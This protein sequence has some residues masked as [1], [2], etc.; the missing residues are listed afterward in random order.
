MAVRQY[1]EALGLP[2]TRIATI[3]YG[4]EKPLCTETTEECWTQNRRA[5][6]KVAMK[7]DQSTQ[8]L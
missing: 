4:K 6:T 2:G 5:V 8:S 1:Y 3:S 7:P